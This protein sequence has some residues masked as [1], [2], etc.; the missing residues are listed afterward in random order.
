MISGDLCTAD[1][2]EAS[3][4]LC[5]PTG[6]GRR[7]AGRCIALAARDVLRLRRG[8]FALGRS[9]SAASAQIGVPSTPGA[10]DA[11][12][13][14]SPSMI[15]L[16]PRRGE[17]NTTAAPYRNWRDLPRRHQTCAVNLASFMQAAAT[18]PFP[19]SAP[20]TSCRRHVGGD[21]R[22][23]S[24]LW[25]DTTLLD[26]TV[27]LATTMTRAAR[28][29]HHR[30]GRRVGELRRGDGEP[31]P[32]IVT[33]ANSTVRM[34]IDFP[35]ER[36]AVMPRREIAAIALIGATKIAI[37]QAMAIFILGRQR[38]QY[39]RGNRHLILSGERRRRPISALRHHDLPRRR[40]LPSNDKAQQLPSPFPH[41][42]D[43]AAAPPACLQ[44]SSL[45]ARHRRRFRH[46]G[47]RA[48]TR[49]RSISASRASH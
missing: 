26:D 10:D 14:P 4:Q 2:A 35:H 22:R 42:N 33:T 5:K 34:C 38:A 3:R 12:T 17:R 46:S 15:F 25:R 24:D 28:F 9:Q 27:R 13:S 23:H 48:M 45:R 44:R 30:Y 1:R 8:I 21:K 49:R 32:P 37:W 39:S 29:W 41:G 18:I 19:N 20:S 43:A 31:S 40:R 11:H 47:R 6:E 7:P 36:R 16:T